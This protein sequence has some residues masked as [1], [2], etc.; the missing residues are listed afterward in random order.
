[1]GKGLGEGLQWSFRAFPCYS[2]RFG[3]FFFPHLPGFSPPPHT[4]MSLHP[5]TISDT[6]FALV[7]GTLCVC[8]SP[9]LH[10]LCLFLL[11]FHFPLFHSY[12]EAPQSPVSII[13]YCICSLF[14]PFLIYPTARSF[15]TIP[16][17]TKV[18]SA[19]SVNTSKR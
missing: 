11:R 9:V 1:M 4:Q 13:S 17:S 3:G 15:F 2:P 16:A 5:F 18:P 14:P 10:H 6:K 7:T 19:P 8:K 12:R